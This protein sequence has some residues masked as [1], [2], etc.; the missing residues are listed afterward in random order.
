MPRKEKSSQQPLFCSETS[1][2]Q[3]LTRFFGRITRKGLNVLKFRF[4]RLPHK[5]RDSKM[6][7]VRL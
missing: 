6:A 3:I 2:N 4:V 5:A 1:C 7:F